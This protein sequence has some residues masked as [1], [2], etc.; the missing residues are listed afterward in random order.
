MPK[1]YI[2]ILLLAAPLYA[3]AETGAMPS[4]INAAARSETI[5]PQVSE[6]PVE[7]ASLSQ[8]LQTRINAL[9]KEL[10]VLRDMNERLRDRSEREWFATGVGAIVVGLLIGL[11][12]SKIHWRR[13]SWH[14]F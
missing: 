1:F 3:H 9:E 2:L 12:L 13:K 5:P 14:S 10:R 8:T 6:L 7:S 11:I 4:K